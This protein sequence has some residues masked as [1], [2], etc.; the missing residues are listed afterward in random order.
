[1]AKIILSW[2]ATGIVGSIGQTTFQQYNSQITVAK[3]KITV[4][5]QPNSGKQFNVFNTLT[6]LSRS[7]NSLTLAQ[8]SGWQSFSMRDNYDPKSS[9]G[10]THRLIKGNNGHL[11]GYQSYISTNMLA[12]SISQPTFDDAPIAYDKPQAPYIFTAVWNDSLKH[13]EV[14][15]TF[16]F[17]Q[18]TAATT[19]IFAMTPSQLFHKQIALLT[20]ASTGSNYFNSVTSKLGAPLLLSAMPHKSVI[21]VQ[22]DVITFKGLASNPTNSVDVVINP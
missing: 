11:N 5:E 20:L 3:K 1:M 21:R 10:G 13:L 18:S 16:Y 14:S 2:L 22:A 4:T 7:W 17:P 6:L 9:G 15:Y 19:R 8:K 12:N